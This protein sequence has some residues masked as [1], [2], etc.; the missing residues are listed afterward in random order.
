M[1][2]LRFLIVPIIVR[3]WNTIASPEDQTEQ[4]PTPRGNFTRK[5]TSLA[6]VLTEVR[7]GHRTRLLLLGL[8]TVVEVTGNCIGHFKLFFFFLVSSLP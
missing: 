6:K 5:S 7:G 1:H 2:W 3:Q 4:G 8:R